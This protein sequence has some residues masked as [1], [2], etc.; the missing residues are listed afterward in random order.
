MSTSLDLV[1]EE[2]IEGSQGSQEGPPDPLE[3]I[4]KPFQT[5]DTLMTTHRTWSGIPQNTD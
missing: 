5:W 4:Y 3:V 2:V 1:G